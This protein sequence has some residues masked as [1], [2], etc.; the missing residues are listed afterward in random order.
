MMSDVNLKIMAYKTPE[1]SRENG[2]IG[3]FSV[4]F[5]PA[6]FTI[7]TKVDYK[8]PDAKGQSGG[9]PVF[10]KIPPMEFSIDIVIDG[11]GV[12]P[13]NAGRGDSDY[14]K[15]QVRQFRDVTGCSINGELHRP[16]Y[17]AVLWGTIFIE[18]VITSL[19]V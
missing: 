10:E 18:C 15:D 14:V 19:S 4:M 8:Q 6:T 1:G 7:E 2:K 5:N 3:E 16:N 17:L 13:G 9:D 11:T 12:G